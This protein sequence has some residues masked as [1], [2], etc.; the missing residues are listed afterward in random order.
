MSRITTG[1]LARRILRRLAHDYERL[2]AALAGFRFAAFTWRVPHRCEA[3]SLGVL[4]HS[5]PRTG[6]PARFYGLRARSIT[7]SCIL[8]VPGEQY[9]G[10]EADGHGVG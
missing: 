5:C 2:P 3:Q 10:S 1:A 4:T 6:I 7:P 9:N 8:E